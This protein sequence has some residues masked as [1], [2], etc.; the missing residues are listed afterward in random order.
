MQIIIFFQ[1]I[2]PVI[3][4][5][6]PVIAKCCVLW[7]KKDVSLIVNYDVILHYVYVVDVA[8]F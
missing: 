8:S 6:P 3:D 2:G 1:G 5:A 7:R 4:V